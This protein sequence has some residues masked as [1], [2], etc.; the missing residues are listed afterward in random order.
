MTAC[1]SLA[2]VAD[3]SARPILQIGMGFFASE[4]LLERR[5]ARPVHDPRRAARRPATSCR[6]LGCS[7]ARPSPPRR[8]GRARLL[9]RRGDGRTPATD[10]AGHRVFLDRG[11]PL[12]RRHTRDGRRR[13]YLSAPTYA[14]R[15]ETGWPRGSSAT[16]RRCSTSSTPT[17]RGSSSSWTRWPASRAGSFEAFAEKFDSR[18]SAAMRH[19]RRDRPVGFDRPARATRHLAALLRLAD[20][21]AD[22]PSTTLG[23]PASGARRRG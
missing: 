14:R 11:S 3:P 16:A 22:Q 18:P 19:R 1:A 4:T 2:C 7:R 13:L 6:A 9:G 8:P 21:A 23:R 10:H 15:F 5:R 20:R 17:R 12:C